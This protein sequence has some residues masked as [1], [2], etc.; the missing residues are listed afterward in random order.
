M[1][2][3]TTDRL[4]FIY[5]NQRKVCGFTLLELMI[6]ITVMMVLATA[7]APSFS[8]LIE[9]NKVKR[10]ATEIEWLLVQ[11]KSESV[12]RGLAVMVQP[13]T[14]AGTSAAASSSPWSIEATLSNGTVLGK[15]SSADF[16]S[17]KI[18]ENFSTLGFDSLTGRPNKDGHFGFF[19]DS[20]K[21]V[22]VEVRKMT[23]RL[24]SCSDGGAYGY[25]QCP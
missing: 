2:R 15:V 13:K 25:T 14:M 24:V 20:S 6:V 22:R 9:S 18:Y 11:A 16:P 10:L 8:A 1:A 17:I 21:M 3:E 4:H 5:S 23:G 12:L 19:A 7:A